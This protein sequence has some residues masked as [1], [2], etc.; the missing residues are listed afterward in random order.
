VRFR[1]RWL[2]GTPT[3]R[4]APLLTPYARA[5]WTPKDVDRAVV[6]RLAAA[7]LRLPREVKNPPA[8]LAWLLRPLDPADRPTAAEDARRAQER[9]EDAW[10][11]AVASPHAERCPH[12]QPGGNLPSPTRQHRTCPACRAAAA[13]V[14]GW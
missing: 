3:S 4:L 12:G 6:D 8:Y 1:L 13:E 14:Q 9:A 10:A 11:R 2:A 5:E 7:G